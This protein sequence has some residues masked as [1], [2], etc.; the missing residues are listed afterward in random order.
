ML[1]MPGCATGRHGCVA[2][3]VKTEQGVAAVKAKMKA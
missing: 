1:N 3:R 2:V